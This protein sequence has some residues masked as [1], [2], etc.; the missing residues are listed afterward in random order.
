MSDTFIDQD[1]ENIYK[2]IAA[3]IHRARENVLK[4]VNHEQVIA[5]WN[6]GKSIVEQ[7]QRGESRA[8]Y[9]KALLENLSRRLNHDF[10]KG[11]GVTNLKYMRQFYLTYQ[12]RISHKPCDESDTPDFNQN[13]SWS[14]YRLLMRETRPESR[15]FYEIGVL[16][17]NPIFFR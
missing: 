8:D 7:E 16:G 2:S 5:Y 15:K 1:F 3:R 12:N 17:A 6:I 10:G 13:L 4:S 9:G 14:H 11:F